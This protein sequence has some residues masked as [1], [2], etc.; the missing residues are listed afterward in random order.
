[1]NLDALF[2]N[3]R[4]SRCPGNMFRQARAVA[5]RPVDAGGRHA[6]VTTSTAAR[7]DPSQGGLQSR[8]G[9]VAE[10]GRVLVCIQ[11]WRQTVA[12]MFDAAAG[13]PDFGM[14]PGRAIRGL[15]S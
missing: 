15:A 9:S 2:G 3:P 13:G 8:A 11:A 12:D 7:F 5:P 1:M 4:R 10:I 6:S 14:G